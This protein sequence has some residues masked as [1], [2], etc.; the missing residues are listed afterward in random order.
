MMSKSPVIALLSAQVIRAAC[1]HYSGNEQKLEKTTK[2]VMI[3]GSMQD[4]VR[5]DRPGGYGRSNLHPSLFHMSAHLS[6]N[7]ARRGFFFE[8]ILEYV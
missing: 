1:H 8:A 4:D 2:S 7:P 6:R 3:R 5:T